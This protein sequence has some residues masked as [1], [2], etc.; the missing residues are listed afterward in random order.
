MNSIGLIES[1]GLVALFEATDFILKNSPVK[2]LGIKNLDNGLLTLGVSGDVEYVKAAIESAV[3]AGRRVGEIYATSVIENPTI[4]LINLFT[5][6]FGESISKY[7]KTATAEVIPEKVEKAKNISSEPIKKITRIEKLIPES[8]KETT[9]KKLIIRQE[10]EIV[11]KKIEKESAK[12]K[13]EP[14]VDEKHSLST[15]ERLRKEALGLISISDKK[16]DKELLVKE[17]SNTSGDKEIDF[18][19]IEKM[20]V[21]KLRHYAREFD[22]FPIKGREISRAN[23]S[24]LVELFKKIK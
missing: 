1:R 2:I 9:S 14:A 23:R 24:E 12:P 19:A 6:I 17:S 8:K 3:D 21:H 11:E 10:K 20:N 22:N 18:D 5:E 13:E 16:A 7:K 4:E 15:I